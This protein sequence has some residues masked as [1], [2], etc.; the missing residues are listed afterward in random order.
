MAVVLI[1]QGSALAQNSDIGYASVKEARAILLK[2]IGADAREEN[3][4]LIVSDKTDSTIWSF[5]PHGHQAYPAVVKRTVIEKDGTIFIQMAA[6]CEADK[7][8]CDT[9]IDQFKA[10]NEKIRQDTQRRANQA[11]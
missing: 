10:I 7:I 6:L 9:L 5:T 2:K 11:R 4:W 1:P 8:P 3:G